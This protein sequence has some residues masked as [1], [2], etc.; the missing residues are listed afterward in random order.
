MKDHSISVNEI[1][2]SSGCEPWLLLP[3]K[4]Q[5]E[6]WHFPYHQVPASMAIRW[7]GFITSFHM[8]WNKG[9]PRNIMIWGF[10]E[11]TQGVNIGSAVV[12]DANRSCSTVW[13]RVHLQ[14]WR[15]WNDWTRDLLDIY[16]PTKEWFCRLKH[17]FE[18]HSIMLLVKSMQGRAEIQLNAMLPYWNLF[19]FMNSR[20]GSS[21]THIQK[22]SSAT[23][24][25]LWALE[26]PLRV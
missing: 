15:G 20:Q 23:H 9:H 17:N 2:L 6:R 26:L 4:L 8:C 21:F 3:R 5:L 22:S 24:L 25:E 7:T 1:P 16:W 14:E 13:I 19:M 10:K 11:C 12:D 18:W